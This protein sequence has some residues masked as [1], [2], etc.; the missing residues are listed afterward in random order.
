MVQPR[1]VW[2]ADHTTPSDAAGAARWSGMTQLGVAFGVP[3]FH[4]SPGRR[5]YMMSTPPCGMISP[6]GKRRRVANPSLIS[7]LRPCQTPTGHTHRPGSGAG[8]SAVPPELDVA[9]VLDALPVWSAGDDA[10]CGW[11]WSLA[12]SLLRPRCQKYTATAAAPPPRIQGSGLSVDMSQGPK[13]DLDGLG[14]LLD[15]AQRR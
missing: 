15:P 2:A 7:G 10:S 4:G 11:S 12:L 6:L 14:R 1:A 5:R 13:G 9:P 8:R 3:A